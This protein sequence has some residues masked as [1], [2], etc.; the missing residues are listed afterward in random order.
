MGRKILFSFLYFLFLYSPV[1]A[2]KA[3][4]VFH[5]FSFGQQGEQPGEF[6]APMGIDVDMRGNIYLADT[7]N[8]RIQKFDSNGELLAF[9]G[10]F[11]WGVDQFQRP[12]D[13]FVFSGLDVFVADYENNRIERYDK[14]L[15]WIYSIASRQS[16][17]ER[18]YFKY[19][20]A[21]AASLHQDYFIIDGEI[22]KVVKL[23]SQF[24]AEMSFGSYDWGAGALVHPQKCA[25]SSAD[26]LYVS[27]QGRQS[28][29]V[30]DYYGNYVQAIGA[31]T[32]NQPTGLAF[33]RDKVLC[34]AE[35]APGGFFFY[36]GR[37]RRIESN[38]LSGFAKSLF[39]DI[40]VF[41]NRLYAADAEQ[42][43]VHAFEIRV[44]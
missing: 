32:L 23:N 36:T 24:E 41:K 19:P 38:Q 16:Q 12:M 42:H 39:S 37:G 14:D 27:D 6:N 34:V 40:A 2:Q 30:F 10:G 33:Y 25:L 13:I 15:N 21:F 20:L 22:A 17:E 9:N 18:L 31:D 43:C 4:A 26:L 11:G 3:V 5:L 8:H 28:I 35:T 1:A 29:M 7:G 44:Q